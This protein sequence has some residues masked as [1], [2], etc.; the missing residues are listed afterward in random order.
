[1]TSSCFHNPLSLITTG[2][3][4]TV[5]VVLP[6]IIQLRYCSIGQWSPVATE[7]YGDYTQSQRH[8]VHNNLL[9][10]L[11]SSINLVI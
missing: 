4:V 1:V 9:V 8:L 2:V 7:G 6:L 3:H 10:G 5:L 11:V